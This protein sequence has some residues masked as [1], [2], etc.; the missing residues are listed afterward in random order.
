VGDASAK[1]PGRQGVE[2]EALSAAGPAGPRPTVDAAEVARFAA[3]AEEWWD[4]EGK[5]R[6][7]HRLNPARVAFI[8][9][10][11]AAHFSRDADAAQPLAGLR[12]ADIGCGGGLLCE[13]L[14]RLG[15]TVVG[16]DA[17]AANIAV[18]RAHADDAGLGIDYRAEAAEELRAAGERFDVVLAMEVVEHVADIDAFLAAAVGVLDEGGVM[19]LATLNRTLKSYAFAIV[20]AEYVLRWLPR[21]THDWRRFLRPSELAAGLRRHGAEI[22][23]LAGMSYNP[24]ADAWS[25]SRD[26]SVNYMAVGR[27]RGL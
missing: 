2:A 5:L 19:I 13:P 21:G 3:L 22:V 4:P 27:R 9:Q 11:I 25:T 26:L 17:A 10:R 12:V 23:E 15:A 6:P 7:L 1:S 8:R 20:G 14:A 16:I 18:A 24:L